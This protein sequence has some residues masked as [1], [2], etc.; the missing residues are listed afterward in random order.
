MTRYGRSLIDRIVMQH[1]KT[2]WHHIN[3]TKNV[4]YFV[5][6]C[7]FICRALTEIHAVHLF[8]QK[9]LDIHSAM[10]GK[11]ISMLAW[12]VCR[13]HGA[14]LNQL[15]WLHWLFWIEKMLTHP[16]FKTKMISSGRRILP[17]SKVKWIVNKLSEYDYD[18]KR[19]D[20]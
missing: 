18:N 3:G 8:I 4:W 2:T 12:L 11:C 1:S 17:L 9:L 6:F 10:C 7:I 13:L 16:I 15:P 14:G 19:L 20:K 5:E